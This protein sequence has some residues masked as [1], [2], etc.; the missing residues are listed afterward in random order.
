M[1]NEE[2]RIA[3]DK[4]T[5][6]TS[7]RD[8]SPMPFEVS[9]SIYDS[10]L[11]PSETDITPR[12]FEVTQTQEEKYLSLLSEGNKPY[13][14]QM[15]DVQALRS[16]YEERGY[17]WNLSEMGVGKTLEALLFVESLDPPAKSVL[18]IC[19]SSL[20]YEWAAQA[21]A[22]IGEE[23]A[24]A[25]DK[26]WNRFDSWF[27]HVKSGAA[28]P[29]YYVV[30]Y[31][32]LRKADYLEIMN[33]L[34]FDF[35]IWDEAHRL[36]NVATKQFEGAQGLFSS[37]GHMFMTGSPVVNSPVDIYAMLA[38]SEPDVHDYREFLAMYTFGYH[39]QWGYKVLGTRN[40]AMLRK[41]VN[42]RAI[43]RTKSEVL[44]ELP[45][46]TYHEI[47]V[48]MGD[49]QRKAYD[50]MEKQFFALLDSGEP[51]YA[52]SA[53]AQLM[54]LRQITSDPRILGIDS[55]SVKSEAVLDI[56]E[57]TSQKLV[58]FSIF[59]RYISQLAE[60]L[61]KAGITFVR[62]TGQEAPKERQQSVMD[63]Q[64]NENIQVC[65]GTIHA[66]GQGITLTAAS[67]VVLIDRWW[68]PAINEQAIDRIHRIGQHWP[69]EAISLVAENTI[70][71]H[72]EEVL[73][74]KKGMARD[75]DVAKEAIE[76]R[77]RELGW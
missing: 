68:A 7:N 17:V 39:G 9:R 51:L 35:V 61:R 20:K 67:T 73:K 37:R 75:V 36:R 29:K 42:E 21:K 14:Y 32:A 2:D 66:M 24:I 18:V 8:S 47:P 5:P 43:R 63:F 22:W 49:M 15:E 38:L 65:L 50:T 74:R 53:M 71:R 46:K 23:V 59:E 56:L 13:R 44:S 34:E 4:P 62:I 64:T 12:V 77:R 60:D 52:P 30:H 41:E 55:P 10:S 19:P 45:E 31:E 58:V 40:A 27:R 16:I 28:P 54:R 76:G 69:V 33:L 11:R 3:Q 26:P 6:S 48:V 72:V 1:G 25:G 57:D 70:D